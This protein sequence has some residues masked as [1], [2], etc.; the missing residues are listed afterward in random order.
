M[1]T[2]ANRIP[3]DPHSHAALAANDLELGLVDTS[4]A[5]AISAWLRSDARGFHSPEP[6]AEY[7]A[8]RA[9]EF[10]QSNDRVTGVWDRPA[11]EDAEPVATIWSWEMGLTVPGGESINAW[12]ISSVTVAPTHRR[13][14]I[15]RALLTAELRTARLAGSALAMLTV[16]EATIYGRY[17]FGPA[18][19]QA[20]YTID[21]KG[22]R[23]IGPVP[24]GRVK[25]VSP[26]DLF[27]I[28][29]DVFNRARTRAPGETD[30]RGDTWKRILG[31]APSVPS[32]DTRDIRAVLYRDA[33]QRVQGYAVYRFEGHEENSVLHLIDVCSVTDDAYSALWRFLVEMDLTNTISAPRRNVVEPVI[34]QVNNPRA[35]RKTDQRDQ[36]WLRILDVPRVLSARTYAAPGIFV[37][38]VHDELEFANGQYVLEVSPTGHGSVT[39]L[40]PSSVHQQ[41]DAVTVTVSVND[42][43][44]LY[45]GGASAVA[46]AG[47]GRLTGLS[48]NGAQAL[49]RSFASP[50]SPHLSTWF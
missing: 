7:L 11:D 30:R 43:A 6:S 28:A 42:L 40:S 17:G 3:I 31:L 49:D 25:F 9:G 33:E 39:E 23:W 1:V 21:T 45:L 35:I 10:A 48:P 20:P 41:A 15:A 13:R 32:E 4:N 16:T 19:W 27:E 8:D 22:L 36:L 12:A 5:A 50:H 46:L 38:T 2:E 26:S 14:G 44:S 47:S 34:W 24:D 29:P 18:A 37:I